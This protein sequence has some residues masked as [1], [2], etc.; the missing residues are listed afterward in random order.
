MDAIRQRLAQGLSP[1]QI[2]RE[3]KVSRGTVCKARA[4]MNDRA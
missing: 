2:T 3:L 4:S 1:M